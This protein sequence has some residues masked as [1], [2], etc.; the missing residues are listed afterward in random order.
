MKVLR[1]LAAPLLF[2]LLLAAM[3]AV[4]APVDA[5]DH[6]PAEVA[7][8]L[9]TDAA[10]C[11]ALSAAVPLYIDTLAVEQ[12][13]PVHV[14]TPSPFVR[15]ALANTPNTAVESTERCAPPEVRALLRRAPAD[16]SHV[17]RLEL[18]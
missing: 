17:P 2:A 7:Q 10:P 6:A 1:R 12:L 13:A 9:V 3:P 8:M 15:L 4:A 14:R 18:T 11:A 16:R 5:V